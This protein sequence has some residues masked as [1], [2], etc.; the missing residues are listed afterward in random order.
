MRRFG[1]FAIWTLVALGA[2]CTSARYQ[3]LVL[4]PN[5]IRVPAGYSGVVKSQYEDGYR[6]G[7]L[8]TLRGF[9]NDMK[10]SIATFGGFRV[11]SIGSFYGEGMWDAETDAEAL[12][13]ELVHRLGEAQAQQVLQASLSAEVTPNYPTEPLSPSL[14]GS[15]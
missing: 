11:G 2:G 14:G 15:S 5:R 12:V 6:S 1:T 3:N 9:A 13:R 4:H 10:Y 7:W 8:Q